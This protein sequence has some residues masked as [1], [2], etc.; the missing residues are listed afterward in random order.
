MAQMTQWVIRPWKKLNIVKRG[1]IGSLD[2]PEGRE[3]KEDH[4]YSGDDDH[5]DSIDKKTN[6]KIKCFDINALILTC[7]EMRFALLPQPH[8]F[9]Q[10]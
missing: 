6:V 2:L 7:L 9:L 3:L 5:D 4:N 8:W 1:A 10:G